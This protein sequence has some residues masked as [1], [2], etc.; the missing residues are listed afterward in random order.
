M[1]SLLILRLTM[2]CV[3]EQE[4]YLLYDLQSTLSKCFNQ[5]WLFQVTIQGHVVY[6][7]YYSSN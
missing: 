2:V 6:C 5:A 4:A 1:S 3:I 7:E